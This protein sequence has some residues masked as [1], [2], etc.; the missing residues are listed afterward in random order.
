LQDRRLSFNTPVLHHSNTPEKNFQELWVGEQS[1]FDHSSGRFKATKVEEHITFQ[2]E[3]GR[4]EG[5]LGKDNPDKGVVITHPHPQYGGDMDNPVVGAIRNAYRQNGYTT[6]R[7]NFRGVGGSQGHFADGIGE[8]QDVRAA[9]SYL[10]DSG[11]NQVDLAGYSFGAWV[12]ANL[13]AQSS[14]IAG[15]VMVSPPVAFIEFKDINRIDCLK[16]IVSGSRDDIAPPDLINQMKPIWN[17]QTRFEIIDGA[18]HFYWG[19][20]DR[21]AEVLVKYI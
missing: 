13:I 12:N 7:F 1:L 11:I 6:L 17:P 15:M 16:L 20:L 10:K 2:S 4:V 18:D 5:R 3:A 21:L 19:Y 8:T 9:L 14:D